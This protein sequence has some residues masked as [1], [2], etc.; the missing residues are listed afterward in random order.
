MVKPT[1]RWIVLASLAACAGSTEPDPLPPNSC[2]AHPALTFCN[3]F[4]I[5]TPEQTS[6][7]FG[8][9]E[10][11]GGDTTA[12]AVIAEN[13]NRG[14]DVT[15][16]GAAFGQSGPLA[17]GSSVHASVESKIQLLGPMPA[18]K[19]LLLG[20]LL[21]DGSTPDGRQVWIVAHDDGTLSVDALGTSIPTTGTIEPIV[22]QSMRIDAS[23]TPGGSGIT[24]D[25][26][27][28]PIG[29]AVP[30]LEGQLLDL[31]PVPQL[32]GA[33]AIISLE[34]GTRRFVFD[35]VSVDL[36]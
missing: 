31:P 10:F 32:G 15:S 16:D 12:V 33:I 3:D 28:G 21:F 11:L 30:I 24:I 27:V 25:V 23:W 6:S 13:G 34:P 22:F 17:I 35:D 29:A 8:F 4:D 1:A 36:E 2:L 26:S 18:G 14:L 9:A 7:P 5:P 19:A 20:L